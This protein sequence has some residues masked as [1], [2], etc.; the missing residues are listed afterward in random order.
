MKTIIFQA[1]EIQDAPQEGEIY[2]RL[3]DERALRLAASLG[4]EFYAYGRAKAFEEAL[5]E[6]IHRLHIGE[7]G[8][9]DWRKKKEG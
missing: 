5:N 7:H 1:D 8:D 4:A 9:D 3:G 6:E 2:A